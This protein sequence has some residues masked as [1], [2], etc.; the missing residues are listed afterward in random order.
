MEAT[1][2]A[3]HRSHVGLMQRLGDLGNYRFLALGKCS[4][5][6]TGCAQAAVPSWH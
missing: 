6:V 1:Y 2:E 4:S 5:D 3:G